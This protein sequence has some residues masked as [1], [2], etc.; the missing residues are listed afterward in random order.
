[1]AQAVTGTAS[2]DG[3]A[4]PASPAPDATGAADTRTGAGARAAARPA[5]RSPVR[6]LAD[7]AHTL[8][9]RPHPAR[10]PAG[11]PPVGSVTGPGD[12]ALEAYA[13]EPG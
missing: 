13:E 3:P 12:R 7:I 9:S 10:V 4:G 2:A 11:P 8:Q 6:P 5:C 1:M